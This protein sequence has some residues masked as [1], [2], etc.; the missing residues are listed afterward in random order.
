VVIQD[1]ITEADGYLFLPDD[2]FKD[3]FPT[4][5][6]KE[7]ENYKVLNK[8]ILERCKNTNAVVVGDPGIGKSTMLKVLFVRLKE[9]GEAVFWVMESGRWVFHIDGHLTTGLESHKKK[10]LWLP[11]NV[12]LLIDDK[13]TDIYL[14]KMSK[15]IVFSSPQKHNYI[16]FLK[17]MCAMKLVLPPWS[18]EEVE[19]PRVQDIIAHTF[20]VPQMPL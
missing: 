8:W 9:N 11:D 15:V 6:I 18:R 19:T 5:I 7:R 16:T 20:I 13:A 17:T 4:R 1:G 10:E 2:K 12:R 14:S 3:V